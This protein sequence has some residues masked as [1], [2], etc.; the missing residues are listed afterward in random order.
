MKTPLIIHGIHG[1]A[2]GTERGLVLVCALLLMLAAMVIGV[3]V[4]RGAFVLLAAASNE[5]D[6]DIAEAA[7]EAA[8]RDAEHDIAG[9]TA[10]SAAPAPTGRAAHFGPAGGAAFIDGCGR[11]ADD[12]GLCL[13]RS[14]PVWQ[15]LDLAAGDNPALVP[16]G[17]FTGAVLAVGG[18]ILPARLPAYLIERV[19]P[20]GATAEQGVFYRITAIG[21]GARAATQVV[22]QSL[23]RLPPPP[24]GGAASGPGSSGTGAGDGRGDLHGDEHGDEHGNGDDNDNGD[25]HDNEHGNGDPSPA[26]PQGRPLPAGRIGWREIANWSELHARTRP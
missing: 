12:R 21:F 16:Y 26:R 11:G 3:A 14:P 19:T 18:G 10:T 25:T 6:R 17:H 2:R 24:A 15:L 4:A 22:L 1:R 20:P 9:R 23:Y 5:R 13:A 8:L 7:A